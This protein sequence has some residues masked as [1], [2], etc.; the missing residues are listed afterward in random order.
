MKLQYHI[1]DENQLT[2]FISDL[3]AIEKN[4]EYPLEDGTDSFYI[5][6]GKKYSPF[7]TQQGYKTRFLIITERDKVIGS[8]AAVWKKILKKKKTYNCIYA[9]DLKLVPEY[10]SKGIVK[11]LLWY[12]LMRWPFKKDFQGWDFSYFCAMQ[13]GKRGV[14]ATFKGVHLGKL[15]KPMGLLN[16]YILDPKDLKRFDVKKITYKPKN[17]VNLSPHLTNEVLWNDGKKNIVSTKD[18]SLLKLGHLNP[19]LFYI[20][21]EKKLEQAVKQVSKRK[22]GQLCFAI[23]SRN[24]N[25]INFLKKQGIYTETK[26]MVFSFSLFLNPLNSVDTI[27]IST[28]E[29]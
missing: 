23:D 18:N 25:P 10:R 5:D 26:C 6:H 28:G 15:T 4:I 29:I 9:S 7:F 3:R 2:P 11:R 8:I 17:E 14:E 24:R 27:S 12:L 19:E 16:I 13:R 22:N 20:E 1:L 21:N